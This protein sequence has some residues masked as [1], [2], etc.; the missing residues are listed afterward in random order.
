MP[1]WYSSSSMP[2][3]ESLAQALHESPPD[4]LDVEVSCCRG[5]KVSEAKTSTLLL[6]ETILHFCSAEHM[7]RY[8]RDKGLQL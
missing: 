8:I 4:L 6:G 2:G 1:K 3:R 7:E 5:K